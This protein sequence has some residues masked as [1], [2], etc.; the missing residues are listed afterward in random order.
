MIIYK[1]KEK[2]QP[3]TKLV[4][5]LSFMSSSK[6]VEV[7]AIQCFENLLKGKISIQK[8]QSKYADEQK[9]LCNHPFKELTNPIF[10]I[11]QVNKNKSR[12]EKAAQS[13]I[14]FKLICSSY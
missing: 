14:E 12:P 3:V 1:M 2:S 4:S 7:N 11:L 13:N 8:F 6:S 9:I 5:L 10:K